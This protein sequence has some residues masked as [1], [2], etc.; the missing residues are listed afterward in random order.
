MKD[1]FQLLDQAPVFSVLSK[2]NRIRLEQEAILKRYSKAELITLEGDSWPYLFFILDGSVNAI[3]SSS[4]GRNLV[5][6]SFGKGEIFW[7]LAFFF[8]NLKMPVSLEVA[9][10]AQL[11]L[12]ESERIVPILKS[13]GESA[14]ELSKLMVN[15]MTRASAILEEMTFQPVAG[16]LAKLLIETVQDQHD[17]PITRSLTLDEMAARIGSTREMVCRFLHRFA[18]DGVIDITRTEFKVTDPKKLSNIAR[19]SKG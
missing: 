12:W 16:R 9:E 13:E 19:Y 5:V 14:W 4:E 6:T 17:T 8:D 2:P 3:K 18:D 10:E 1:R 15:K 7:G 11:M